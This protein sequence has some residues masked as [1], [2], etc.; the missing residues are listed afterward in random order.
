MPSAFSATRW[1]LFG[2]IGFRLI[3][4]AGQWAILRLVDKETFGA[5]R[6]IVSVHLML[7]ALLPLGLDMLLVREASRRRRYAAGLSMALG[8][9]GAFFVALSAAAVLLPSPGPGSIGA[10]LLKL[11]GDWAGLLVMGPIFAIQA[12]KLA[13]RAPLSAR[14]DFKTISIGEFGNGLITWVGGAGA[15]LLEASTLALL[16]AYLAGEL[17]ECCWMFR[18]RTFRPA[19]VLAPRRWGIFTKL[20]RRHRAFCL[21]NAADLTLNNVAAMMPGILLVAW[22]SREANADF[23]VASTLVILPVMLLVGAVH[24]VTFPSISG[25]GEEELHRRCLAIV[26]A[27]SAYVAPLVVWLAFFSAT[28]VWLLGGRQYLTAAPLV[29]WMSCYMLFVGIFA[30]ISSL[31]VVR[32]RPELGLYWNAAYLLVRVLVLHH[33]AG[34]G[35]VAAVAAM[36]VAS[37]AMWIVWA[38]TLG[39]LLRS[40]WTRF[41]RSFAR[42]LPLWVGLGLSFWGISHAVGERLILAPALSMLPAL[43]YLA[44]ILRFFPEEAKM[45]RRLAG[46]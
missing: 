42:F 25:I 23:Q 12:T 5:Y 14:L 26:G 3:A 38:A 36:S 31:D 34:H 9:A 8:A 37:V 22:V 45:L 24:R 30:P 46:R 10:S 35:V 32:D 27:T 7:L 28:T 17:F 39:W 44:A 6:A 33:F 40:G 20:F 29:S 13:I 4:I 16:V 18:G 19:A 2:S 1:V 41:L 43:L 15:V 21:F 11:G